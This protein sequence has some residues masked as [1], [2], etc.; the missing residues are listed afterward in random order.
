MSNSIH[1]YTLSLGEEFLDQ[2]TLSNGLVITDQSIGVA[3]ES[4]GFEGVDGILGYC[5][6]FMDFRSTGN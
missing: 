6:F 4:S 3:S 2:V 5:L 1:S